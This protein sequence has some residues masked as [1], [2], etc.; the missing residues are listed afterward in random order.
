M[1]VPHRKHTCGPPRPVIGITFFPLLKSWVIQNFITI[2]RDNF[3]FLYVDDV[4]TSQGTHLW[5][6][7]ACYMENFTFL[8]VDDV[9]TSQDTPPRRVTWITLHFYM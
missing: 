8:Y 5:T 6:S 3:T 4:L 9:R 1:F 2:N 7:T